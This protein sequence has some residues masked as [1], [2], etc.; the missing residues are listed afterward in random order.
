MI[1]PR[2]SNQSIYMCIYI[3]IYIYIY[4]KYQ[5]NNRFYLYY[6]YYKTSFKA[7]LISKCI[8]LSRSPGP[9]TVWLHRLVA[10]TLINNLAH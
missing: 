7:Y 2:F 4:I 6:L 5:E 3:Y 1:Y 9:L 8:E 10:W